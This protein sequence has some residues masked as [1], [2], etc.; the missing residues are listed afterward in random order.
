M[1]PARRADIAFF[2]SAAIALLLL[3]A[4]GGLQRRLEMIGADDLSRIW[5]GPRA[6]LAGGD[7]YDPATWRVMTRALGTLEPDTPV[8][9]YPPWVTVALIPLAALPLNVASVVW[10]AGSV[11]AGLAGLR[12]LLRAYLPGAV[13]AHA[14]GP[15]MLLLSWVGALSLVI[16]QWGL[17]LVGAL[18][19][20]AVWLD[21]HPRRAGAV[22]T[23]LIAKPQL[24]ILAAPAIALHALWPVAG[25]IP[26]AGGHFV[27]TA[28]ALTLALV[29]IA[30]IVIPSWWPTW[31]LRIG[32]VQLGPDSDTVPGLL[33]ALGGPSAPGFA[34]LIVVPLVALGLAFH[35][36]S[37]AWL[38][39]WLSLSLIVAPYMNSYDQIVLVVPIVMAAGIAR[40]SR[41]ASR[42]V[43]AVG[44]LIL[45][46]VTP[47]MYEVALRR[48]S[49]TLGAI[50]PLAAYG[51]VVAALWRHRR[52]VRP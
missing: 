39:V 49:E 29:G 26:R 1:T 34:P 28:V 17:I 27:A 20:T 36:R 21:A 51:L 42:A 8:F 45:I 48:H 7:P 23:A 5:A 47:V 22:A 31:I 44:A 52:E 11:A 37:A 46:V 24:F 16:G 18:S 38:P 25:R 43:L 2:T 50:V 12:L 4:V 41:V 15:A 33:F 35:P 10:L 19:A 3:V 14:L 30:W 40:G 9:I 6:Y 13:G 32:A